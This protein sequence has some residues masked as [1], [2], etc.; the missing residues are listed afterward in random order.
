MNCLPA[1]L[2][3]VLLAAAPRAAQEPAAQEP[4]GP[5]LKDSD[6][7]KLGRPFGKWFEA[8]LKN[9]FTDYTEAL[10]DLVKECDSLDKKLKTRSVLSLVWDWEKVLD[11]GRDYATSGSSVKKGKTI[12]VETAAEQSCAIRL[13]SD[14]N[15]SKQSYTGVLILAAGKAEDTLEA[16]PPEL[17][18][19]FLLIGVDLT[20]LDAESLL[21]EIGRIRMLAPLGSASR[22]YRLDRKRIFLVG[23]GEL[24]VAAASRLAA[25]YPMPFAG[26]AWVDGEPSALLNASNLKLLSTEKKADMGEALKWIALQPDRRAYPTQFEVLLTEYWQGR[27]Y[28]VQALRFDPLEAVPTGKIARFKVSVDRDTNTITLDSEYVY[29]YRLYLNDEIVDLDEEIKIIRNGELYAFTAARS[30]STLL[31]NFAILLDAGMVFPAALQRLDVPIP[32]PA[33]SGGG[34]TSGAGGAAAGKGG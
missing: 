16:L 7:A 23:L 18:D 26:C 19:Q 31:D 25:I 20:G 1:V 28:W 27:H 10:A 33:E 21:G 6:H 17:K 2:F 22:E 32:A 5:E 14:Y 34:S 3:S 8:K 15:P 24:G 13:P 9:D 11:Q 29:Q 4:V 30:V 12:T